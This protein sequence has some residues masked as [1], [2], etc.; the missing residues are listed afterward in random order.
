MS[1][2]SVDKLMLLVDVGGMRALKKFIVDSD[3][4]HA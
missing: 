3:E 4:A 1:D 2:V